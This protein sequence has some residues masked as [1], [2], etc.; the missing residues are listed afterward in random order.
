MRLPVAL[1]SA[2]AVIGLAAPAHAD[3]TQDHNF[4]VSLQAAGITYTSPESAVAAGKQ[5]C[6]MAKSGKP[7]VEVVKTLQSENP[8]LSQT[9]AAKFTAISASV[10][11]PDQLPGVNSGGS[12]GT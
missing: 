8:G 2:A 3:A 12:G 9:N 11:C 7:G 5:V 4:V 1:V 6:E 10:Y